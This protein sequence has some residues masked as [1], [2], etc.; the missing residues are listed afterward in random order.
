[1]LHSCHKDNLEKVGINTHTNSEEQY[2]RHAYPQHMQVSFVFESIFIYIKILLYQ[3]IYSILIYAR[4]IYDATV[5][6]ENSNISISFEMLNSSN[7]S[8]I[9]YSSNRIMDWF[10][11][12]YSNKNAFGKFLGCYSNKILCKLQDNVLKILLL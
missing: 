1:M 11:Y 4:N 9:T 3:N 10:K 2:Y 6:I 5:M 12:N 8:T 7:T